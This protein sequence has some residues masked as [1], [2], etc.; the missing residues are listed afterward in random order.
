MAKSQA[1]AVPVQGCATP[2]NRRSVGQQQAEEMRDVARIL[3]AC[4]TEA[5]VLPPTA[6]YN[7]GWLLRLTL[8]ALSHPR[9]E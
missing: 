4:G 6:L 3:L 2:L 8:E 1:S 9:F 7:E 5:S